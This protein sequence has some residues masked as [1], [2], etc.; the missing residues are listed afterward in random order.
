M[1]VVM[2]TDLEGVAGV[3]SFE[4]DS[5]GDA[6]YYE[7]AKRLL[8]AE[9]NAAVEGLLAAG[10]EDV[11]VIDGHGPGGIWFPD[12]HPKAKLM[13]GRPLAS[14]SVRNR[15]VATY[16]VGI[17][18]GQHAMAG[19]AD[20]DLAH[21]QSSRAIDSYTLNGIPIGETAQFALKCGALGLPTIF[22]SGDTAA[23]REVEELVPGIT[24]A[25]VKQGLS[26]NSAI[27]MSKEAARDL[28]RERVQQAVEKQRA[29][30][31]PP[32]VLD[33]PYILVKRYF[34]TDS[35]DR[36]AEQPYVER[37]DSQTV[38]LRSDN[39]LDILYH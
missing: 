4:K 8:T 33:P 24:T 35:A 14:E 12:L 28:I 11:L 34:H 23:C 26:R 25:A 9:V 2:M 13:H 30:P 19:V 7:E 15:I 5:Y 38:Q 10:V 16:D 27:S 3:V 29:D 17:L 20:G 32:L 6:P 39:I 22:L 37:L 1:R 18:V 31:L 36:A 21:T